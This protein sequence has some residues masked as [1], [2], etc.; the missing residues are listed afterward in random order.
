MR[1]RR[2]VNEANIVV[3][4]MHMV[5]L[6]AATF[7]RSQNKIEMLGLVVPKLH[8]SV[9]NYTDYIYIYIRN[10]IQQ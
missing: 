4:F 3:S 6:V 5:Q 7:R 10:N 9:S 2:R 8:R 1:V